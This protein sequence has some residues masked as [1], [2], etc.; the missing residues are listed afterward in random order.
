M[1]RRGRSGKPDPAEIIFAAQPLQSLERD[2]QVGA[3]F[4]TGKGM[5]F[6][7]DDELSVGE[8]LRISLLR[9]QNG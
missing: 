2:A 1:K 7:D 8:V 4:V 3:A 5:Q 9:Q 6:V